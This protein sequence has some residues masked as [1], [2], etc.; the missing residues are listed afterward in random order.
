V[1]QPDVL[2]FS[3][4]IFAAAKWLVFGSL[5]QRCMM[6]VQVSSFAAV[7]G[8][9]LLTYT[10]AATA[11]ARAPISEFDKSASEVRSQSYSGVRGEIVHYAERALGTP[12]AW[13]GATPNGFDCSGLVYYVYSKAGLQVPR[14]T[15]EQLDASTPLDIAELKPGDLVFFD[16]GFWQNHVGIYVGSGKFVHAPGDG[17]EVSISSL[18]DAYWNETLISGGRFLQ[19]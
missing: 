18:R 3:A 1:V 15:D 4:S 10:L 19:K 9:L 6:A 5:P 11:H 17:E 13:G 14:T 2:Q 8:L 12:Y 7:G 16:T